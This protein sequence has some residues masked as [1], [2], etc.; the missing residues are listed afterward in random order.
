MPSE[1]DNS[2]LEARLR[3]LAPMVEAMHATEGQLPPEKRDQLLERIAENALERRLKE[4]APMVEAVQA[5]EGQLPPEKMELLLKRIAEGA[6]KRRFQARDEALWKELASAIAR[7]PVALRKEWAKLPELLDKLPDPQSWLRAH[8]QTFDESVVAHASPCAPSAPAYVA[9]IAEEIP[10]P[11][12]RYRRNPLP[13]L[14]ILAGAAGLVWMR[15][16]LWMI[17]VLGGIGLLWLCSRLISPPRTA[18]ES[19]VV[20]KKV[21]RPLS[22]SEARLPS[23]VELEELMEQSLQSLPPN[24][25]DALRVN[26]I[27]LPELFKNTPD[28]RQR[29]EALLDIGEPSESSDSKLE[30]KIDLPIEHQEIAREAKAAYGRSQEAMATVVEAT[31]AFEGEEMGGGMNEYLNNLI[32]ALREEMTQYGELLAL[33]QEQQ[34]LIINRSANELLIN[35][36]DVNQQVEKT[37]THREQRDSARRA[38]VQS[39]GGTE[40]TT[41]KQMTAL[42]PVEYQPLLNALVEEINQLLQRIQTWVKHNHLLLKGSLDLMSEI[43]HS[44]FPT[45]S[46]AAQTYGRGGTVSP[47]YSNLFEAI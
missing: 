30:E 40:D 2:E 7:V 47:E 42:L 34:E 43:M 18:A 20:A 23:H 16:W 38:L 37:S 32:A 46:A 35:L 15:G 5:T 33:M 19:P 26:L 3:E 44:I 45:S 14:L 36:H 27:G 10:R 4:L 41:F 22:P 11:E 1:P 24:V 13:M 21:G 29:W 25:K 28:A 9:S 12:L 8:L 17:G 39:L 31:R 6:A